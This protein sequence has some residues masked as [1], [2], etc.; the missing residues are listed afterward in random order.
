MKIAVTG[1]N[2]NVGR[3]VVACALRNGHEVVGI[4][5]TDVPLTEDASNPNFQYIQ[6]DLR[7]YD[8]TL[9][10]L[11]GCTGVVH[12]AACPN[13][14]DFVAVTHNSNVVMSWNMLR[15]AA[16]LGIT[17]IAQAS[18][19]NVLSLV[20][21]KTPKHDYFPIDEEHPCRPDEPYG[22]SKQIAELQA[23][24]IVRRYPAMRIASLRIHWTVPNRQKAVRDDN[25]HRKND[26]WGYAEANSVAEAF[27]LA[28]T[29]EDG[30]WS[31][32]ERFFIASPYSS[33]DAD[34]RELHEQYYGDVPV[35]EGKSISGRQG[36]F[37]CSKAENLLGWKH[38]DVVLNGHN[39][40]VL[41]GHDNVALNGHDD[42]VLNGHNDV[43]LNGN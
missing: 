15:A 12:L 11:T 22:L 5:R 2:G 19:V 8:T 37:D 20:Y 35:K 25:S 6:A 21:S 23:D 9:R 33:Q 26:L 36:F 32:H 13:P 41:N 29:V 17:R 38:K 42:V 31:G 7:D 43:V 14:G 16:E 10:V 39:D 40:V 27:L 18:S 4:D 30:K 34:S 28:L 3:P 24:A 1:C